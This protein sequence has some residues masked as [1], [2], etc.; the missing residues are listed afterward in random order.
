MQAMVMCKKLRFTIALSAASLRVRIA[1][2]LCI[3]SL[4]PGSMGF[5][6]EF[7]P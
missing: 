5:T 6:K 4:M 3:R 1:A 7:L 2:H